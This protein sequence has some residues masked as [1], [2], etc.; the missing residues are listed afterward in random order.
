MLEGYVEKPP[1]W[2]GIC[3]HCV[4][5]HRRDLRK[6]RGYGFRVVVKRAVRLRGEGAVCYA[7]DEKL[8]VAGKDELSAN[9][10]ARV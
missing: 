7:A 8:G 6:I 5:A 9:F 10:R 4:R 1:R 3:A 2:N